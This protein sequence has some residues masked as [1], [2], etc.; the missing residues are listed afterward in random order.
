MKG[1]PAVKHETMQRVA[2][3]TA[4]LVGLAEALATKCMDILSL[5]GLRVLRVHHVAAACERIPVQMP[6]LIVVPSTMTA[7]DVEKLEDR[8]V[9]VGAD[10]MKIAPDVDPGAL[11]P[12]LDGASKIALLR[13]L[14]G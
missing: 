6:Q 5:K 9:A 13:A 14:R 1:L 12:I 4:I 10:V 2:T 7:E 3:P 8:A 11:E